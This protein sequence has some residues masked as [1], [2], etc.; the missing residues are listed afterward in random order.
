MKI[1]YVLTHLDVV[2]LLDGDELLGDVVR[3]DVVSQLLR[4]LRT[5][6]THLVHLGEDAPDLESKRDGVKSMCTGLV[7]LQRARVA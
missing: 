7:Q 6:G 5:L 1:T 3:V 4:Q 2:P